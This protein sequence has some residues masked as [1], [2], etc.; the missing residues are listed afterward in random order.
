[1]NA[2]V[3]EDGRNGADAT[4]RG[5]GGMYVEESGTPALGAFQARA[6]KAPGS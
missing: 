4:S 2:K 6:A 5:P 3:T 1:M